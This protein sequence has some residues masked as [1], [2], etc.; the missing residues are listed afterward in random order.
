MNQKLKASCIAVVVYYQKLI[1][2]YSGGGYDHYNI[3]EVEIDNS[4][5][6]SDIFCGYSQPPDKPGFYVWEGEI[7]PVFEDQPIYDGIWRKATKDD[8]AALIND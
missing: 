7:E 1:V 4:I 6:I 5:Y 8:M 3:W 2:S